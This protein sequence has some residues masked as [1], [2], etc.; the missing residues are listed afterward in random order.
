MKTDQ[1]NKEF[2]A[3]LLTSGGMDSTVLAYYLEGKEEYVPVF[4][5]YGQHCKDTELETLLKLLPE[6]RK[7][8]VHIIDLSS[9]FKSSSSALIVAKNLWKE[10]VTESDLY[11]PYRNLLFLSAAAAFAAA[12]GI[13]KVY[14]A[15]IN[16]NHAQEIDCSINFFNSLDKLLNE[17]GGVKIILPFRTMSKEDVA[18]LGLSLGVP[19]AETFSCQVNPKVHCGA[20]PNCVERLIALQTL[21]KYE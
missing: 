9:V 15:F 7:N 14:A 3:V 17:Y 18:R 4:I 21:T 11:L 20:C 8:L 19:I 12:N 2:T 13:N 10:Q 5:D 1:N 6:H 16:T